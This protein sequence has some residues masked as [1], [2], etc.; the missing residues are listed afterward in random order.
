MFDIYML[1]ANLEVRIQN[2]L[3]MT[4]VDDAMFYVP[5]TLE[6]RMASHRNMTSSCS[7]DGVAHFS[8]VRIF[9]TMGPK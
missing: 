8:L 5:Q 1:K 7:I 4:L 9:L 2:Q 6:M 3:I